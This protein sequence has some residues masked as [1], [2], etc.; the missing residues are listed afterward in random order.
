MTRAD[1]E[2]ILYG[3][4]QTAQTAALLA[5]ESGVNVFSS[6]R[7]LQMYLAEED[8]FTRACI[9]K[10]LLVGS[11]TKTDFETTLLRILQTADDSRRLELFASMVTAQ[12][13]P[14]RLKE[15][16]VAIAV[17]GADQMK[18]AAIDVLI[19][20]FPHRE[21]T[22]R[23]VR[24]HM[25]AKDRRLRCASSAFVYLHSRADREHAEDIIRQQ[26]MSS[27]EEDRLRMV[28][29]LN[30]PFLANKFKPYLL[31]LL[32][33]ESIKVQQAIGMMFWESDEHL[34]SLRVPSIKPFVFRV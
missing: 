6:G 22:S 19:H 28:L 17:S 27:D 26:L 18:S 25:T 3:A 2:R 9:L 13:Y 33:G 11:A 5:S 16:I 15:T 14:E 31:P 30:H 23:Y 20:Y 8:I 1:L 21:E 24:S 32:E 29:S 7:L 12:R 10:H 4:N 34:V